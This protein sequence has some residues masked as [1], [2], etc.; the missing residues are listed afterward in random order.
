MR[1][2]HIFSSTCIAVVVMLLLSLSIHPAMAAEAINTELGTCST[3]GTG[4]GGLSS[5]PGFEGKKVPTVNIREIPAKGNSFS[6]SST[7][8]GDVPATVSGTQKRHVDA[9]IT[10]DIR[11]PLIMGPVSATAQG[12]T[13]GSAAD[14]PMLASVVANMS[15]AGYDLAGEG[16][17]RYE[18][19]V[20]SDDF[21]S[22]N[23]KQKAA[24]ETEGF[25]LVSD[26]TVRSNR[27]VTIYTFTHR[28]T[29]SR[30]YLMDVQRL[31][32]SGNPVGKRELALSPEFTVTGAR[33]APFNAS[34]ENGKYCIREWFTFI[35]TTVGLVINLVLVIITASEL[36]GPIWLS[37]LGQ[38]ASIATGER[39]TKT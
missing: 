20:T 12:K 11:D 35:L 36:T 14:D 15:R 10:L 17:H 3:C 6:T 34:L 37:I 26:D 1:K 27:D 2:K 21:L 9:A 24:L 25:I 28:K 38:I 19:T 23:S 39:Y 18:S 7:G 31:D 4:M 16:T 33:V 32:A 29:Q 30:V 8:S 5:I 13:S 22:L